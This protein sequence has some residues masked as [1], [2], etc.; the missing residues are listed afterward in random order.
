MKIKQYLLRFY[1]VRPMVCEPNAFKE[2]RWLTRSIR[3]H[4]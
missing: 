2:L 3:V 1:D 4:P